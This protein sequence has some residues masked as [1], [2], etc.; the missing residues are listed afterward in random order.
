LNR[1]M[2]MKYEDPNFSRRADSTA[3]DKNSTEGIEMKPSM[4]MYNSFLHRKAGLVLP[5]VILAVIVLGTMVVSF[6][7]MNRSFRG[8]VEV[9]NKRET[10]FVIAYSAYSNILA[11]IY[12]GPWSKRYFLN[13]AIQEI[14]IPLFG[15]EY[16]SFVENGPKEFQADIY[17]KSTFEGL[18]KLYFWRIIFQDDILDI[19]NRI[20]P[21]FFGT[22]PPDQM[23]D[24]NGGFLAGKINQLLK[25]RAENQPKAIPKG[26]QISSSPNIRDVVKILSA[27]SPNSPPLVD[28]RQSEGPSSEPP[29]NPPIP[30]SP[31]EV[32]NPPV[33]PPSKTEPAGYVK[34]DTNP[35][36]CS[37]GMGTSGA[38][39]EIDTRFPNYVTHYRLLDK[40]GYAEIRVPNK[41]DLTLNM[42]GSSGDGGV[43]QCYI[44]ITIN[45]AP[46][47]TNKFISNDDTF[48]DYTIPGSDFTD[49]Q[50]NKVQIKMTRDSQTQLWIYKAEMF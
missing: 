24:T 15:G 4:A 49:G 42:L 1:E 10:T 16:E 17:I 2:V 35:P 30:E 31:P 21:L 33:N 25:K 11:K 3:N 34:L 12:M 45:G 20:Q 36:T 46:Y 48:E 7:T 14:G 32:V 23:P 27:R 50:T 37:G 41:R 18:T 6:S 28:P 44:D 39:F 13:G 8:Q 5:L 47:W 38:N 9:V 19:T 40:D 22:F 26:I 29:V 43:S